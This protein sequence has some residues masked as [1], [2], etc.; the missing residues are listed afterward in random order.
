MDSEFPE[1]DTDVDT[2]DIEGL[3]ILSTSIL[4]GTKTWISKLDTDSVADECWFG[5]FIRLLEQFNRCGYESSANFIPLCLFSFV[6]SCVYFSAAQRQRMSFQ[7][8]GIFSKTLTG[9]FLEQM[10]RKQPGNT[11]LE[12]L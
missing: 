4:V 6:S 5:A 8:H 3:D 1:V 2:A 12:K 9:I 10:K 11:I 7:M